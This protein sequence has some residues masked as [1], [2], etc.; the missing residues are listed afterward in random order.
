VYDLVASIEHDSVSKNLQGLSG[1]IKAEAA[2]TTIVHSLVNHQARVDKDWYDASIQALSEADIL[3]ES[4]SGEKKQY[5]LYSAFAEIMCVFTMSYC[6]NMTFLTMGRSVPRL[7]SKEEITNGKA[8][9]SGP[10]LLDWTSILKKKGPT[11]DPSVAFAYYF[12]AADVDKKSEEYLRISEPARK[13]MAECGDPMHPSLC[14]VFAAEDV[15][16]LCQMG[17]TYYVPAKVK[18]E[19]DAHKYL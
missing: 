5:L 16:M 14:F 9:E 6:V 7:P 4:E 3:P 10:L 2:I 18:R 19:S 15:W 8:Q 11:R 17:P 12:I 1:N 13:A